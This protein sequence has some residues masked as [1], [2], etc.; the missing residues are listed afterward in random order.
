MKKDL[1]IYFFPIVEI[2]SGGF[3]ESPPLIITKLS[4]FFFFYN[5]IW[6]FINT[7][8]LEILSFNYLLIS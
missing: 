6:S 2:L 7:L 8:I 1:I 5:Y 4:N 3:R